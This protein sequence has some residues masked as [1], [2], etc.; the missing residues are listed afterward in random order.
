MAP[1]RCS[2][3]VLFLAASWLPLA[4]DEPVKPRGVREALQPFND[5]I[6]NWRG[7]GTPAGTRAE[8]QQGFWVESL[9][10]EWQFKGQDA[11]IKVAFDKSKRYSGG[12]LRYTQ[13]KDVFEMMLHTTTRRASISRGSLP[14]RS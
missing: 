2:G 10:F 14:T 12:E 8:Q 1:F 11:W 4:A 7:T 5:L 9:A 3:V 13:A 6:G